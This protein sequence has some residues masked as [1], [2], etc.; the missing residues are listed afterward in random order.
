MSNRPVFTISPVGRQ[1]VFDRLKT[2]N[3]QATNIEDAI[4]ELNQR[5]RVAN[6]LRF[7]TSQRV[8]LIHHYFQQIPIVQVL[9][10]RSVGYGFAFDAWTADAFAPPN[11]VVDDLNNY[12]IEHIDDNSFM[13]TQD[14]ASPIIIVMRA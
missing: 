5:E 8:V 12:D 11:Y 14:N 1:I 13:F 3:L 9:T 4:V 7:E 10:P 2:P 6:Y